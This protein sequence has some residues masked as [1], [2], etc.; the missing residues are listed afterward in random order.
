M[1]N[2]IGGTGESVLAPPSVDS[3]AELTPAAPITAPVT[4]P[5]AGGEGKAEETAAA[6]P[7]EMKPAA[8]K[9]VPLVDYILNVVRS[10]NISRVLI[11]FNFSLFF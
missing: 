3:E 2:I 4:A 5:L 11:W 6:A 9:P 8:P 10:L 7:E 1:Y